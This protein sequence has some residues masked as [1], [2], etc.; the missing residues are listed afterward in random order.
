MLIV[1]FLATDVGFSYWN[2]PTR[3]DTSEDA[4]NSQSQAIS[5]AALVFAGLALV[6]QDQRFEH[7][8]D[9]LLVSLA[10]FVMLYA[11]GFWPMSFSAQI[12]GDAL[13]WSGLATFLAAVNEFAEHASPGAF[14]H[15]AILLAMAA[16]VVLSTRAA[17]AHWHNA[18]AI[19]DQLKGR[20][21]G[22]N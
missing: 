3:D 7:L 15:W 22:A 5:I 12:A 4:G 11:T 21:S 1:L 16:T 18:V 8:S 9:F 13:T 14:R 10:C 6:G 19:R 20:A 2:V 17:Y